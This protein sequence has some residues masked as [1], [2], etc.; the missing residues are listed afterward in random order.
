MLVSLM[1]IWDL[2]L[3]ILQMHDVFNIVDAE[4]AD[5]HHHTHDP[6]VSSVSIVCEGNLDL[7]KAN[8]WLG[9]LL[10]ERS[11]DI[12][13]TKGL[14]SVEGMNERFVFQV[15]YT[16]HYIVHSSLHPLLG[17]VPDEI[18]I[19]RCV[20][21]RLD[22]VTGKIYH[23]KNFPPESDEIRARLITRSD[24]TAEKPN[25]VEYNVNWDYCGVY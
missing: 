14:L 1:F 20:G 18:L 8:M 5:H 19:D 15:R 23:L 13:R 4:H 24:D 10:L 25:S 2:L 7:D 6:G 11:D 9:T 12:Y 16:S 3:Y 17:E 21:R 22:P